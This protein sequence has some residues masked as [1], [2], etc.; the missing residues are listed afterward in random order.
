MCIFSENV[1]F[2][3]QGLW[4]GRVDKW[5]GLSAG[6]VDKDGICK[7]SSLKFHQ[8]LASEISLITSCM[9]LYLGNMTFRI[10]INLLN[11]TSFPLD[12]WVNSIMN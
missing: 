12:G 4:C 1:L 3:R 6:T 2:V 9:F 7:V 10:I 11:S 5:N 8:D